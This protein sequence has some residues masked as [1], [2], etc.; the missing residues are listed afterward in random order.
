MKGSTW[1]RTSVLVALGVATTIADA[2]GGQSY[3]VTAQLSHNGAIF[4]SPS[5]LV[6]EDQPGN[7]EVSGPDG[8][9]L[10]LTLTDLDSNQIKVVSNL[11][12]SHG[13]IEPTVVV[14][15][16]KTA[17]VSVGEIGI[18]LLVQRNGG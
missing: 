17:S 3:Q 7:F 14:H 8:Y 15:P 13:H 16:G 2:A 1:T 12:S 10:M 18:T 4:A 6:L 5:F 9:K 11:R